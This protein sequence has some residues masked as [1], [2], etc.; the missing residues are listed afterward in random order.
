MSDHSLDN[1]LP[2]VGRPGS[3]SAGLQT[4]APICKPEAAEAQKLLEFNHVLAAGF[5]PTGILAERCRIGTKLLCDKGKH[6]LRR[7]FRG[8][9]GAPRV[10]ERAKLDSNAQTVAYP[11]LRPDQGQVF[12]A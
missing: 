6:R 4:G 9:E 7:Q 10:A 3:V 12:G 1:R 5:C 11:P 2:S 8:V